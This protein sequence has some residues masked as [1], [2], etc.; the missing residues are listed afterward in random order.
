M[1]N[2]MQQTRNKIT[3]F[4]AVIF[5]LTVFYAIFKGYEQVA[6]T[7]LG[8]ITFIIAGYQ[9]S[10]GFTKGKFIDLNKNTEP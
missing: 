7:A 2:R 3:W 6:I 9:A 1:K 5:A 8:G 4:G 10:E